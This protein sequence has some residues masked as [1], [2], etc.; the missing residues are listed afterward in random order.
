MSGPDGGGERAGKAT[1]IAVAVAV[2]VLVLLIVVILVLLGR[3]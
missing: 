3:F 2:A 1:W